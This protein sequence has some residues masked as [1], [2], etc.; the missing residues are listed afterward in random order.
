[1]NEPNTILIVDDNPRNLQV[2]GNL[3][4]DKS[5]KVAVATGGAEAIKLAEKLIPDLILLDIMMPGMDGY[6]TCIKI[7]EIPEAKEIPII[8]L[9]A[10]TETE[11][12][13]KGFE[14]GGVDYITKPFRP[15][16]VFARINSHIELKKSKAIIEEQYNEL[17]NQNNKLKTL[18]EE[19]SEVF[20]I[21]AHDLKNP[22]G[23][24]LS[25]IN[26]MIDFKDLNEHDKLSYSTNIKL[27]AE[28]M[29]QI[30]L[31]LLDT[32]A[33]DDGRIKL[34]ICCFSI[35]DLVNQFVFRYN[36][37][38]GQ[39]NIKLITEFDPDNYYISSDIKY[40]GHIFENL[41][42]NALKYSPF[43]SNIIIK[44]CLSETP[45]FLRVE[46]IDFGP[47]IREQ[48]EVKLFKKFSKLSN[49]PTNN[50][51]STG[52]GLSIAKNLSEKLGGKVGYK[53]N[54]EGGSIFYIEM[55]ICE[56]GL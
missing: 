34:D 6:E 1:M 42:S 2:I 11:D 13:V 44:T 16:E 20:A 14:V 26:M 29:L 48:E 55:P 40:L 18:I 12:I 41:L 52:L 31:D 33:I 35:K 51:S 37:R 50:E 47:G 27:A 53:K 24:I 15:N 3:L 23:G 17:Q 28:Q 4:R 38:A 10:K 19:R 21:A 43:N 54:E 45:N 7:K 5:Y 25:A 39:K 30:V 8:F 56:E 32:A 9:T 46:V 36:Q 49:K 22:I